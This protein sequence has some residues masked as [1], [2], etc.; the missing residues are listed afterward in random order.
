MDTRI[1]GLQ[2]VPASTYRQQAGF[3]AAREMG[4]RPDRRPGL[5]GARR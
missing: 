5:A 4:R 3:D 2:L 1:Q